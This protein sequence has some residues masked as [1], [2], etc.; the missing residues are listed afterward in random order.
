MAVFHLSGL[1]T[2]PARKDIYFLLIE[3]QAEEHYADY[4]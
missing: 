4:L 1:P 3:E 2:R